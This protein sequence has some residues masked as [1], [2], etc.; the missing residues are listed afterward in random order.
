MFCILF[1]NAGSQ[2]IIFFPQQ[3][4]AKKIKNI[5]SSKINYS[6]YKLLSLSFPKRDEIPAEADWKRIEKSALQG[7]PQALDRLECIFTYHCMKGE[8]VVV[9]SSVFHM[10]R[11][12]EKQSI[13]SS[14]PLQKFG[15]KSVQRLGGFSLIARDWHGL[16]VLL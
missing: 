11:L 9:F 10:Y 12:K 6:S 2:L 5:R 16:R 15:V 1:M 13:T 14:N 4:E 7:L 8:C 3:F